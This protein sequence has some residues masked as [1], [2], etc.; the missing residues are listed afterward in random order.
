[1]IKRK[2]R[3]ITIALPSIEILVDFG[4][5]EDKSQFIDWILYAFSALEEKQPLSVPGQ[6]SKALIR[7]A[8]ASIAEL[9]NGYNL[10]M[11]RASGNRS[12]KKDNTSSNGSDQIRIDGRPEVD[13]SPTN[14]TPTEEKIRQELRKKDFSDSEIEIGLQKMKGRNVT[15][16]V[17]YIERIIEEMRKGKLPDQQYTQRKYSEEDKDAFRRMI[18]EYGKENCG[19]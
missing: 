4:T 6:G 14:G 13:Q 1:M 18:E 10:Y 2:P 16:P 8:E 12:D 3:Y 19:K 15:N 17:A 7:A 9:E 5:D 11:Q